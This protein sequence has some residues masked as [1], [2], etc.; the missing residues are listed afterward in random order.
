MNERIEQ[1]LGM[2]FKTFC[3]SVLLAQNRFSEFLKATPAQ[4]DEVLKGV[5][6]FERLDDALRVAK[7]HVERIDLEL[8]SLGKE[9]RT[10][11]RGARAARRRANRGGS[12]ARTAAGAGIGRPRD[13]APG[14]GARCR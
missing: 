14:E 2:D 3:R 5:F 8:T 6:G 1:L 9:R 10:D 4:R 7:M 11:R 12:I 13:R